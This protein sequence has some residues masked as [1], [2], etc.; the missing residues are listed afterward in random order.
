MLGFHDS[1]TPK[2]EDGMSDVQEV[3]SGG[4]ESGDD[5]I[6]FTAALLNGN[7]FTLSEHTGKVVILNFW[8]TWCEPSTDLLPTFKKLSKKF[9]DDLILIT[10][11]SGENAEVIEKFLKEKDYKF[12]VALDQD[13]NVKESYRVNSLP[14]TVLIDKD[15][16]VAATYVGY[17]TAD[18]MFDLY[19]GMIIQ[20]LDK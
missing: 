8:A 12:Q 20:L 16:K 17:S 18:T 19:D 10:V 1:D 2:I 15:G 6:D 5:F 9:G 11:N 13:G 4:I 14:Y 7:S 3:P